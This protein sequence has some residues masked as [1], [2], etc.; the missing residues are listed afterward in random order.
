MKVKY[1]WVS[2]YKNLENIDLQFNSNLVTLLVGRNGLGK[3]NLIE[4]LALI[5]RELDLIKSEKELMSWAYYDDRGHFE[6]IIKY[7]CFNKDIQITVKKGE[8]KIE[9]WE[10]N[11]NDHTL[12]SFKE[13]KNTKNLYL[14]KYIIGYYSGENK[15]I[16]QIISPH[17]ELEQRLQKNWHRRKTLSERSLRRLFFAENKHSQLIL[18]TLA[19]YRENYLFK[20]LIDLLF[21]K[22]LNIEEITSFDIRFNNPRSGFYKEINAGADYFEENFINSKSEIKYPFWN[23]K[24]KVHDLLS[25]LFNHHLENASYLIYENDGE[26]KRRFVKEFLELKNTS[27]NRIQSEIYEKFPHPM[28]FFDALE[29]TY[30]LEILSEISVSVKLEGLEEKIMFNNLSEG[31]QQILSV[32]GMLLITGQD[33]SLFL[34]DEPDTHI[35]PRWQRDYVSLLSEFN[36]N[37]E[38]SQIIVA[39]HSPLIVQSSEN[40]DVFL[41]KKVENSIVIDSAPHQLHN[42]RID[43][44]LQSDYFDF[45]STRPAHLDEFMNRREEILNKTEVSLEDLNYLKGLDEKMGQLPSGETLNDFETLNTLYKIVKMNKDE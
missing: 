16:N 29:S 2:K 14:P 15:R 25:I 7:E 30:N 22:Y 45:E 6:F 5:F 43:Q 28:D 20:D 13:W 33:E 37:G 44:V 8:Y 35:N 39:T 38:K 31:Q 18:I 23:L 4:I 42:W 10:L 1:L 17:A 12:L 26:D 21:K 40:S 19:I 34:F 27:I 9:N 32:I 11:S 3:S 36:L 41:F 24:G